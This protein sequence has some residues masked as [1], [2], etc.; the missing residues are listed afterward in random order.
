DGEWIP[1]IYGGNEN[2]EA[3]EFFKHL[4]S[5]FKKRNDGAMIIAEESTAWPKVTG[6]VRENGLGFDFKWNMG[7]MN[8]FLRYMQCDPYFRHHHY[9][10]LTFSMIY[11]YSER[12]ILVFSHDEVVHGKKSLFG[13]MP[14]NTVECKYANLRLAYG[15]QMVHPGKKLLF[16]GQE[17]AMYNEWWEEREIDW[18]LLEN[19]ENRQVS[20]YVRDLNELYKSEPALY[21]LDDDSDGFE[22]INNISANESIV[23]FARKTTREEDTIIVIC[24]FDTI[25]RSNYKIGVPKAGRYK[26]IFNSDNTKY[27]GSGFVNPRVKNSKSDECDYRDNSIRIKVP[28]LG[29]SVFKYAGDII[30]IKRK[31]SKT[32]MNKK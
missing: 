18:Y 5:V 4:N 8:D 29:M 17:F 32:N 23:V 7:W 16:M 12:F 28:A 26:E 10:E 31:K 20:N 24:N 21:E 13:K 25:E 6:N 2:L 19:E 22:W 27:G 9:G 11:A 3:I 30:P 15:Y 1:N 14:G